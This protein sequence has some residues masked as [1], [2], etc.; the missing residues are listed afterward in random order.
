MFMGVCF[1]LGPSKEVEMSVEVE[2]KLARKKS[3]E[4]EA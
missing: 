1:L 2:A 3:L 4:V